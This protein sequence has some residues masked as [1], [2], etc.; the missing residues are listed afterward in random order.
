[1]LDGDTGEPCQSE[2]GMVV[3]RAGRD[4]RQDRKT[5]IGAV[6]AMAHTNINKASARHCGISCNNAKVII[7]EFARMKTTKIASPIARA[8]GEPRNRPRLA[9]GSVVTLP[10]SR[11]LTFE[12]SGGRRPS[13]VTSC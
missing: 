8:V 1:L 3:T 7:I 13:A 12:F 5:R 10:P 2:F 11:R 6:V 9:I 4:L